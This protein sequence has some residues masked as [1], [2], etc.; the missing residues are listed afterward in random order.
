[1]PAA[2]VT[3]GRMLK[4][5]RAPADT[6]RVARK[7]KAAAKRSEPR[8]YHVYVIELDR[9]CV[10]EPSAYAPLYVGQ[11][12]HSPEER[13]DQHKGGGRLSA[14]KA[15]R[16]GLRLRYDLMKVG[17]FKTR[18]EAERAERELAEALERRG[19]KVFWG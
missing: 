9:A 17:P 10:K 15:R 4:T 5:A 11:T 7:R 8:S 6:C 19:H 16:F 13:F 18:Q 1:M 3:A 2:G 12:A 14:A